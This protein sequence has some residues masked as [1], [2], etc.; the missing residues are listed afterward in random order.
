[1]EERVARTLSLN[2]LAASAG[3]AVYADP[4]SGV[5]QDNHLSESAIKAAV[6]HCIEVVHSTRA[7]P[8]LFIPLLEAPFRQFDAFYDPSTRTITSN[9]VPNSQPKFVFNKCIA[10]SGASTLLK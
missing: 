9:A 10:E 7:H 5:C 3:L 2:I 6:K 8:G 1:M 4:S